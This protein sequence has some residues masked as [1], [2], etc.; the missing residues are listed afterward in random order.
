MIMMFMYGPVHLLI[1]LSHNVTL[2][3][4]TIFIIIIVMIIQTL[5]DLFVTHLH[6]VKWAVADN[7]IH[8]YY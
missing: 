3:T 4:I 2:I 1:L 8:L 5:S 6:K 7:H